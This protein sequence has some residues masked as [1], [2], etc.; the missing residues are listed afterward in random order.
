MKNIFLIVL[1]NTIFATVHAQTDFTIKEWNGADAK[2]PF[3]F[4][5]SGDG[6]LNSFS[7]SVC[8][9]IFSKAYSITA[10]NAKSYFWDKKTPEQAAADISSYLT[11][12]VPADAKIVLIGYSF[13]ADVLPFIVN[14]LPD[15][16]KHKLNSVILL[17]PSTS[18]DFEI[19]W[20]DML[21]GN[22]KRKMDVVSEINKLNVPKTSTLFGSDEKEFPI[23]NIQLKNYSNAYLPGGHHFEGNT[24]EVVKMMM[25]YF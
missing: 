15:A 18:T 2:K 19:H 25:N 16:I 9:T 11:K 7:T 3:V 23:K 21:G 20:S 6:G 4:Y 14:R 13:G 22:K 12:K 1:L 8:Q 5:I 24:D 17:S 10:L